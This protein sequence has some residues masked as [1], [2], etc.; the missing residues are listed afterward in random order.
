M[1]IIMVLGIPAGLERIM[2]DKK[3]LFCI[4]VLEL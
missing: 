3:L 1:D 4:P 2:K